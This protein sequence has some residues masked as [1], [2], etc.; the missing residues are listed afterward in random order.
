MQ[1]GAVIAPCACRMKTRGSDHLSTSR[2]AGRSGRPA[3]CR[4]I[5]PS[6]R[7]SC[8]GRATFWRV[9]ARG[10]DPSR[11]A[12][13]SSWVESSIQIAISVAAARQAGAIRVVPT[14]FTLA[15][16]TVRF[17]RI[18]VCRVAAL[19]TRAPRRVAAPA[20]SVLALGVAA[21]ARTHRQRRVATRVGLTRPGLT[22]A[23]DTQASVTSRSV[24]GCGVATAAITSRSHAAGSVAAGRAAAARLTCRAGT[25]RG[26][27]AQRDTRRGFTPGALAASCTAASGIASTCVAGG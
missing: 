4:P 15:G 27:A 21:A 8:S 9:A 11:C 19:D 6:G 20:L 2:P 13:P 10:E 18:A 22:F 5:Y 12:G 16:D 26:V 3:R 25:K 17:A 7:R 23:G 1:R 24:R 14:L